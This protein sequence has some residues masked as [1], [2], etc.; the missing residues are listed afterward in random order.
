MTLDSWSLLSI[1]YPLVIVRREPNAI[2]P[3][4]FIIFLTEPLNASAH[5]SS[6][7]RSCV[8]LSSYRGQNAILN[9]HSWEQSRSQDH[10]TYITLHPYESVEST[11]TLFLTA[12]WLRSSSRAPMRSDSAEEDAMAEASYPT[13]RGYGSHLG[14]DHVSDKPRSTSLPHFA[15]RISQS[16]SSPTHALR[17][18]YVI[19]CDLPLAMK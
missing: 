5:K 8:H 12:P 2:Y 19:T 14:R 6:C 11:R 10:H 3:T 17:C 18:I 16:T 13:S 7:A 15:V 9:R 4:A 1:S